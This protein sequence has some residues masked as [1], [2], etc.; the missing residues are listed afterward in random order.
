MKFA[1]AFQFCSYDFE[2][3]KSTCALLERMEEK[4]NEEIDF[5]FCVKRD[6][7][8]A[9]LN[10]LVEMMSRKFSVQVFQGTRSDAGWPDGPNAQWCETMLWAFEQKRREKVAWDYVFTTEPDIVPLSR[11]WLKQLTVF[12]EGSGKSVVGVCHEDHING[13]AFF[14]TEWAHE[15]KMYGAPSGVAWDMKW[16]PG[17]L[18]AGADCPL[19]KNLYKRTEI[20]EEELYAPRVLGIQPVFVHGIKDLS[21]QAIVAKKFDLDLNL[22]PLFSR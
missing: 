2:Q 15:N 21:A 10:R 12:V 8:D 16:A 11:D 7:K 13:N 18:A 4:P 3:A 1:L 19:M 20:T 9:P 5:V 14:K 17:N 22:N 6:L